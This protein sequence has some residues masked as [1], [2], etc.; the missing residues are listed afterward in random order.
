RRGEPREAARVGGLVAGGERLPR[1]PRRL[2]LRRGVR[3]RA[4][5][6]RDAPLHR[7]A[8]L[9]Q[10]R[11]RLPRPARPRPAAVLL[12]SERGRNVPGS[13]PEVLHGLPPRG[14]A[15]TFRGLTPRCCTGYRRAARR[16]A[17]S[18][19]RSAPASRPRPMKTRRERRSPSGQASRWTGGWTTCWTPFRSSGPGPPTS[20]NPFTRSTSE[21]RAARSIVS[22]TPKAVQSTTP[23]RT[24]LWAATP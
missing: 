3:R 6:P 19:R 23:S 10:P 13:D 20:R 2:R 1:R 4:E 21:P 8:R 5:V 24:R 14:A 7:R 15:A 17:A 16:N 22:Q 12:R 11:P 9:E 18:E